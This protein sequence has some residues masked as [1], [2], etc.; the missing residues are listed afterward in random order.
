MKIVVA[1]REEIE[2][3][4]VLR[5]SYVV[6][7]ITDPDQ[8]AARIPRTSGCRDILRLSFYDAEP[9]GLIAPSGDITLMSEEDC[10]KIAAFVENFRYEVGAIVV[11]CEQGISRSPAVAAALAE[12]CGDDPV[13]FFARYMPNPY[14]YRSL[15]THFLREKRNNHD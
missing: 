10:E 14:V 7:S 5:S 15:R 6:I 11:H 2:Q 4:L 13:V 3:G 9:D 8:S 12:Y 1:S